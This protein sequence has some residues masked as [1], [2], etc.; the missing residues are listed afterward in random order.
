MI[1]SAILLVATFLPGIDHKGR[2]LSRENML[3][4]K[5]HKDASGVSSDSQA[6]VTMQSTTIT[7]LVEDNRI[8][9]RS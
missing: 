4:S 7:S 9:H 8:D 6:P 3:I 2:G 5:Y 1:F